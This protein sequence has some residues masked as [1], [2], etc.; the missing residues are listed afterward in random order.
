MFQEC[1]IED[2][3]KVIVTDNSSNMKHTVSNVLKKR[4]HPCIAHT[5]NLSANEALNKNSALS[6]CIKNVE[7]E[8]FILNVAAL[9][10]R[11]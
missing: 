6:A 4:H 10:L 9:Q 7:L 11:N 5:L 1:N 3:V 8:L 2:K